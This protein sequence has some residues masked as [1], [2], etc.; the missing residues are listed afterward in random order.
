M[1]STFLNLLADVN[2]PLV[3]N[4]LISIGMGFCGFFFAFVIKNKNIKNKW[5][6]SLRYILILLSISAFSNAYCLGILGYK[7][8]QPSELLLHLS[9]LVFMLWGTAYYLFNIVGSGTSLTQEKV[10]KFIEKE[11]S[12]TSTQ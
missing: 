9:V 3:L 6:T 10:L 5:F 11:H 1:I 2:I 7:V 12:T 8:V 4:F